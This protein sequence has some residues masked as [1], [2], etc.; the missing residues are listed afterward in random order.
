PEPRVRHEMVH[1]T[2]DLLDRLRKVALNG[3][4]LGSEQLELA[5]LGLELGAEGGRRRR[6]RK[7]VRRV[8]TEARRARGPAVLLPRGARRLRVLELAL[9]L[10]GRALLELFDPVLRRRDLIEE[11]LPPGHRLLRAPRLGHHL[12]EDR[13]GPFA[14]SRSNLLD[15]LERV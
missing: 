10:A 5:L 12:R 6:G 13:L 15:V 2:S 8:R 1:L 14:L 9:Q 4:V 7:D 11:L 3:C